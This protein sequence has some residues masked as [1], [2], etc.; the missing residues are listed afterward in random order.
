MVDNNLHYQVVS[1]I[2]VYESKNMKELN[3]GDLK[4]GD[5]FLVS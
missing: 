3:F 5:Q 1:H 4:M 2:T